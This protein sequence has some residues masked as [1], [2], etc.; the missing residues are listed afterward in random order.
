VTIMPSVCIEPI[1][2]GVAARLP[3]IGMACHG[4]DTDRALAAVRA[5]V[6]I[7]ARALASDG[8]LPQT[9]ARLGVPWEDRGKGI[10]IEPNVAPVTA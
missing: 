6:G 8:T 2:S 9:L 10:V 7:W 5:T 4:R 1:S 3:E